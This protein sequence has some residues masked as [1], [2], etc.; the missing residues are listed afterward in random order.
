MAK[1]PQEIKQFYEKEAALVSSPF[2]TQFNE[3]NGEL[4]HHVFSKLGIPEGN[5]RVVLDVG[6]GRGLLSTQFGP[7]TRY[8]GIDLALQKTIF[9]LKDGRRSFVQ[10][11][12]HFLPIKSNSV[13]LLVCLD[14]FEHYPD[15]ARAAREFRRV[16]K[17]D[18][19]L[20]LSI[21]TYSNVAGLVK[22]AYE[23]SGRVEP[24]SWAPFDFWKKQELEQFITPSKIKAIFG[25]AGFT[26]MNFIGYREEIVVGVFPWIWHPR[27]PKK[28][29]SLLYHLFK[30][31]S[32]P[33]NRWFPRLSLHTF[34]RIGSTD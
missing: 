15:M 27:M 28:A 23:K 30:W 18:G 34:W 21:P 22:R 16:L 24:F 29:A 26:A 1:R 4:F 3:V 14:S 17:K 2:I 19:D 11:D 20:F 13:D 9:D 12:G 31:F 33:L 10:G 32:A 5:L 25:G 8:V 7:P 6:C